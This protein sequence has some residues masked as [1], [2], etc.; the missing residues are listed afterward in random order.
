MSKNFLAHFC[1]ANRGGGYRPYICTLGKVV[2]RLWR[3]IPKRIRNF[4]TRVRGWMT[5]SNGLDGRKITITSLESFSVPMLGT[6]HPQTPTPHTVQATVTATETATANS[7]LTDG[8]TILAFSLPRLNRYDY[9]ARIR[10]DRFSSSNRLK[11]RQCQEN[12]PLLRY[13]GSKSAQDGC[14][15]IQRS[16]RR[17]VALASTVHSPHRDFTLLSRCAGQH[18]QSSWQISDWI[19]EPTVLLS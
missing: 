6:F 16:P 14:G 10:H 12:S 9:F 5:R 1:A 2:C 3:M 17:I 7:Q 19:F 4:R 13:Y 11:A 15:F 8:D 18:D